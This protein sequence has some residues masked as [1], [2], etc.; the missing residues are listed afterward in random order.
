MLARTAVNWLCVNRTT[1]VASDVRSTAYEST[2]AEP[3]KGC[4]YRNDKQRHVFTQNLQPV[5]L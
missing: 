1:T 5:D 2:D 4:T 3:D